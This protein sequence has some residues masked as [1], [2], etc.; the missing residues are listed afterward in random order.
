M[1]D[2]LSG[3]FDI[4]STGEKCTKNVTSHAKGG[5]IV[6]FHDSEKAMP[7]MQKALAES[8]KFLS[9]KGFNFDAIG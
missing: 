6:V 9:E 1:W 2:V 8:L 5:S 7:R 3:Y 4:T